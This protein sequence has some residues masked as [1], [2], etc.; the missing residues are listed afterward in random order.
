[1]GVYVAVGQPMGATWPWPARTHTCTPTHHPT[2]AQGLLKW[3]PHL[4]GGSSLKTAVAAYTGVIP[5]NVLITNGRWELVAAGVGVGACVRM[6]EH[7]RCSLLL[8]R[9]RVSGFT[10]ARTRSHT[11]A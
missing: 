2:L 5:E 9:V 11:R 10:G 3:Y 6:H 1:V 7:A 8:A 4:G